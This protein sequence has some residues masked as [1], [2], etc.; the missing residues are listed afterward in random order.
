MGIW[1]SNWMLPS[2]FLNMLQDRDDDLVQV[3]VDRR[4]R[5]GPEVFL[6]DPANLGRA[7]L[8]HRRDRQ[9]EDAGDELPGVVVGQG[10]AG[11][12]GDGGRDQNGVLDVRPHGA[13][14]LEGGDG[15]AGGVQRKAER[16]CHVVSAA[17]WSDRAYQAAGWDDGCLWRGGEQEG[18]LVVGSDIDLLIEGDEHGTLEDDTGAVDIRQ[19]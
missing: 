17:G 14:R 11:G 15:G 8:L 16:S 12:G 4:P 6:A 1:M 19:H 5:R 18:A 9:V 2:W 7:G 3:V 10:D 13:G